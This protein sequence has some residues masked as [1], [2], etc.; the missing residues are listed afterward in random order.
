M[1][2][3]VDVLDKTLRKRENIEKYMLMN[4]KTS[5]RIRIYNH[6][7]SEVRPIKIEIHPTNRCN[8]NCKF[9]AYSN[10]NKH[11]EIDLIHMNKL[12]DEIIQLEVKAVEFSGGGEPLLYPNIDY[13]I[14][15]LIDAQV[16]IGIVTNFLNINDELEQVLNKVKW[17]RISLVAT[18]SK[19][20][21]KL[22]GN[23]EEFFFSMCENI[24]RITKNK[25]KDLYIGAS[26][27][28]KEYS[29]SNDYILSLL[30]LAQDLGLDQVFLKVLY[31]DFIPEINTDVIKNRIDIDFCE[32]QAKKRLI[33]TN[34]RKLVSFENSNF[35]T[36][37]SNESCTH[38]ENN[39]YLLINAKGDCYGCFGQFVDKLPPYGNLVEKS[40]KSM[41]SESK[42]HNQ[43]IYRHSCKFCRVWTIRQE[44]D[45]IINRGIRKT[46]YDPHSN[47]L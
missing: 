45:N 20:Y 14:E 25:S 10:R 8:A 6:I 37:P 7:D 41:L 17:I 13:I 24:K 19:D 26:F 18:N 47:F 42:D 39:Y 33:N 36:K 27:M 15:R 29:I 31:N 3:E 32:E 43:M 12:V 16:D 4:S 44:L 34:L 35:K 22:T 28:I 2:K 38:I 46:C 30:D 40:L 1:K 5:R 11:E 23:P 21:N 9:C